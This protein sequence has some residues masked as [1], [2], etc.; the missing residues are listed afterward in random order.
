MRVGGDDQAH[1]RRRN[2]VDTEAQQRGDRPV[3]RDTSNPPSLGDREAAVRLGD[4]GDRLAEPGQ[5][6][7]ATVAARA[8]AA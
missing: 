7:R 5:H 1:R 4:D 8:A 2:V 6:R 3:G